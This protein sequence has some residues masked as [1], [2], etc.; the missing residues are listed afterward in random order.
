M[1]GRSDRGPG[2]RV[3][4]R[5]LPARLCTALAGLA[6]A[7]AAPPVSGQDLVPRAYTIT[8]LRSNAVIAGYNFNHGDL[9]FEGTVPITD[10]TGRLSIPSLCLLSLVELFGR[11]ANVLRQVGLRRGDLRGGGAPRRRSMLSFRALRLRLPI[12]GEPDGRLRDGHRADAAMA[13]ED[14]RRREP[15]GRGA[16]RPVRSDQAHQPRRQPLVVQA[17]ARATR[18]ASDTGSSTPTR[19]VWFFTRNPEFFSRNE[20]VPGTQAQTQDPIAALESH[21]SYDVKP[22]LLGLARRQLLVRRPDE[23]QRRRE[24]GDAAAELA[25]RRD[26][27]L[28]RDAPPVDQGRIRGREPTSASAGTTD[29]LRRLAVLV[30][31]PAQEPALAPLPP[32]RLDGALGRRLESGVK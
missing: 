25:H 2:D 32:K 10:A 17:G 14:H 15:E 27:V 22:R 3:L 21:L 30:G 31:G 29:R 26:R 12:V 5:T 23:P 28:S 18:G 8:P 20:F 9:L 16:D 1:A 4:N 24:R 11:S 7:N 19:S 6:L 13:A